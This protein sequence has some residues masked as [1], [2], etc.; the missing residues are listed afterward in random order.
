MMMHRPVLFTLAGTAWML[1]PIDAS[2]QWF[3][4][5]GNMGYHAST[6]AE[7]EG[8][9]ISAVTRSRGQYQLDVSQAR[10]NNAQA[11][12]MVMQNRKQL[13]TDYFETQNINKQNRFGDYAEK[14]KQHEKDALFQYGS[15]GR[16]TRLTSSELDPVTGQITWPIALEA[17]AFAQF[18][19]PIDEAFVKRAETK[20]RLS[21]QTYQQVNR[22]CD[23]IEKELRV[24]MNEMGTNDYAT[25][26]GFVRR[27]KR[28][29]R[30][31]A[32]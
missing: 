16:P 28:E 5:F 12:A 2:A 30:Y 4:G 19:K 24:Q 21:Y 9:A 7:G 10:I 14:K 23:G 11:D 6:V 31:A 20:S 25:A 18:T 3:G 17:P 1:L 27:L 13:A 8:N 26:R 32:S 22:D 29:V 15:E